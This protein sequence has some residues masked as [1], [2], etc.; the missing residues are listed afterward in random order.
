MFIKVKFGFWIGGMD[1]VVE[2][3]WIW[4]ILQVKFFY[5]DWVDDFFDDYEGNED[6]VYLWF[7]VNYFWND[8]N[9][10]ERMNFICEKL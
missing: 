5:D 8:F 10:D 9:C 3:E 6:C 4:I 2:G 1:V 7:G